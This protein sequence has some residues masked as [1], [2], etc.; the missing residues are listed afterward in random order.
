MTKFFTVVVLTTLFGI[1]PNIANA[2]DEVESLSQ[3]LRSL[4]TKEMLALENGMKALIPA[5]VAGNFE[6]IA[7]IASKMEKSYIL[8][9]EIT[10][11]Q[12]HELAEKLP[13]AFLEKDGQ[14]HHYAGQLQH[15]A[16][17]KNRE[18]IG[19]YYSKLLESCVSC[20]SAYA[21]HRFPGLGRELS[22]NDHHH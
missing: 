9:Q 17:Q 1:N 2:S 7:T 5:Y 3:P 8:K 14:F 22:E 16:E 20:H 12:K 13:Q 21:T 15:V 19:F 11:H 4:L 6:E 18:L 10:E